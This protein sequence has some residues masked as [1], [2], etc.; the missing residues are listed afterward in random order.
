MGAKSTKVIVLNGQTYRSIEEMPPD[1]REKYE[2]AMCLLGDEDEAP[3]PGTFA[4][5]DILADR[6][7]NGKPDILESITAD[8]IVVSS[9]KVI[10]DGKGFDHIED[11]PPEARA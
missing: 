1:V 5:G 9:T 10:V 7:K 6:N 3:L 4:T 11:L 8:N 2:L